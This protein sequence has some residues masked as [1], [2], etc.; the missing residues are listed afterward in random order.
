MIKRFGRQGWEG[1]MIMAKYEWPYY[2]TLWHIWGQIPLKECLGYRTGILPSDW[3]RWPGSGR[4]VWRL[5]KG[6]MQVVTWPSRSARRCLNKNWPHSTRSWTKRSEPEGQETGMVGGCCLRS[7]KTSLNWSV[8]TS[9]LWTKRYQT[10]KME[11]ECKHRRF[12]S[13]DICNDTTYRRH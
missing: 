13:T 4:S 10:V 1:V 6:R 7:P 8:S 5:D 12:Q 2:L 11:K 3:F 9:P